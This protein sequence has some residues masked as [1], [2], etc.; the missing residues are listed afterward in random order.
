MGENMNNEVE[1]FLSSHP[2]SDDTKAAYRSVLEELVIHPIK[3]W[4]ASDLLRFVSRESW[5]N[6]RRYV[7]LCACRKFIAWLYGHQHPA[8]TAR[9]KRIKPKRQRSLDP[10][11]VIELLAS[12]DPYTPIGARDLALAA[13]AID[14]GLRESELARIQLADVDLEH[15]TLQVIVKGGQWGIAIYSPE[16]TAIIDRWLSFRKP[17]DGNNS[18]FVSLRQSKDHG[19]QLTKHGIKSIFKKWGITLGYKLSPHDARR[20]FG[21]L[22][23][24]QGAPQA[25]AMAA[26]RWE[27]EASFRRYTQEITA[28]AITPYLPITHALKARR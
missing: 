14:T 20:T 18:L 1:N 6:S 27:S 24:L 9:V 28:Q 8:L 5:G 17:A 13:V 26:G 7:N 23:T 25:V 15:R 16:T 11:Q 19:R 3:E 10:N 4:N 21:N 2:Y 22:V 12:F